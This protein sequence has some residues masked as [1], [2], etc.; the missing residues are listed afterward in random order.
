VVLTAASVDDFK[1]LKRRPFEAQGAQD[2][3]TPNY[4]MSTDAVV[5]SHSI[6]I[7]QVLPF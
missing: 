4:L 5:F 6:R 7:V 2:R 1:L 3:R